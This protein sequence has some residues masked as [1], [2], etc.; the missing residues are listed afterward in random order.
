MPLSLEPDKRFPIVLES[1]IDKPIESRPTF[2]A[3]S[4][5][6]RGYESLAER[7]DNLPTDSV[8]SHFDAI[9][10]LLKENIVDASNMGKPFAEIDY[11]ELLTIAEAK[12]L[13][14]KVMANQHVSPE[15]KKS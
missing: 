10:E 15:E 7:Y 9:V 6:M 2:Y 13:I 1:D 12:E 3:L 8:V 14:R 5:S 4:K 11:R